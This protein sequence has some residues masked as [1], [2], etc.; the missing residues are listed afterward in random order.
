MTKAKK[1]LVTGASRGI[2]R[3]IAIKLAGEGHEIGIHYRTNS[4]E[5]DEVLKEIGRRGGIA[6]LFQADF[7]DPENAVGLGDRVWQRLGHIDVLI[8]N[9]GISYK[10]N[11]LATTSDELQHF[12]RVNYLSTV[13]LT[14]EV[15]RRQLA[16]GMAGSIYS[17]TSVNA[18]QP[19]N[20]L[21]AYGASKGALETFMKGA[22]LEL[23]RHGIRINTLVVG[24][25]KTDI[26]AA[27]WTNSESLAQVEGLIPMGRMG[28]AEEVASAVAALVG[29]DTYITGTS[30]RID[31]GWLNGHYR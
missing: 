9:A 3:A 19:G 28:E 14:Q 18:L 7:S 26:N 1:I 20:G 15:V 11:V 27:V 24:A 8:N 12:L 29:S 22:A 13:M 5:A 16:A 21:S 2:G 4:K 23:A 25:I 10:R 17:I 30:I 6:H 31:G